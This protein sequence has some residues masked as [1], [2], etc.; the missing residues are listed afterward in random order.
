MGNLFPS[1][2]ELYILG[3]LRDEPKGLYG[4]EIVK[5]SNGKLARGTVYV[6]LGRLE[7]KG[8]IT[9]SV[10][11]QANHPGLPRRRYKLTGL[12]HRALDAANMMGLSAVGA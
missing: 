2:M 8:F 12:G 10:D 6:L 9:A 5:G 11:P 7:E 4:L 1:K 3:C